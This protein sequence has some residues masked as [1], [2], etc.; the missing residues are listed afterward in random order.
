MAIVIELNFSHFTCILIVR[1]LK[2]SNKNNDQK[3][4]LKKKTKNLAYFNMLWVTTK[5]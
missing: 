4:N 3:I 5:N 2:K 1:K